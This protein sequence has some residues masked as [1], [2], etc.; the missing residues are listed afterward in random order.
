MSNDKN[1]RNKALI[2]SIPAYSAE[3]IFKELGVSPPSKNVNEP[4]KSDEVKSHLT[5]LLSTII[6]GEAL[7]AYGEYYYKMGVLKDAPWN[8]EQCLVKFEKLWIAVFSEKLPKHFLQ[9][10][11]DFRKFLKGGVCRF[12]VW[13]FNNVFCFLLGSRDHKTL[14]EFALSVCVHLKNSLNDYRKLTVDC[15]DK[16]A[17]LK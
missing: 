14:V 12:L 11:Q 5:T 8:L 9:N 15:I 13:F 10:V 17:R 1:L 2:H 4:N 3:E 7:S 16:I 6:H